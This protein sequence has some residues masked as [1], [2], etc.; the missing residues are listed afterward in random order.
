M[1]IAET[2][3][4]EGAIRIDRSACGDSRVRAA[5]IGAMRSIRRGS[6]ARFFLLFKITQTPKKTK[7]ASIRYS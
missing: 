1:P 2:K 5:G 6:Q 3:E 4:K 7:G